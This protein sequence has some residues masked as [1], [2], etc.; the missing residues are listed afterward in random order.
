MLS[1]QHLDNEKTSLNYA[2]DLLQDKFEELTERSV[3]NERLLQAKSRALEAMKR[4]NSQL[5][6][7]VLILRKQ[8]QQREDLVREHGLVLVGGEVVEKEGEDGEG[9]WKD[10]ECVVTNKYG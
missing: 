3:E 5:E 1:N 4:E 10:D 7:N 8:L 2:V 6:K 9:W